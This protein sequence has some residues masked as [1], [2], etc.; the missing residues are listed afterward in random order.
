M[1][2]DTDGDRWMDAETQAGCNETKTNKKE[3]GFLPKCILLFDFF[4]LEF[5][6]H[7]R[8]ILV[9]VGTTSVDELHCVRFVILFHVK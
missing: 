4:C 3:S 1:L 7:F 6:S 9:V 8:G 2:I 5:V